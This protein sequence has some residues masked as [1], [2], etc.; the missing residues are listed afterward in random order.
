VLDLGVA[1]P[2]TRPTGPTGSASPRSAAPTPSSIVSRP[3]RVSPSAAVSATSP[4]RRRSRERRDHLVVEGGRRERPDVGEFG[5]F[6]QRP[7]PLRRTSVSRASCSSAPFCPTVSASATVSSVA[8]P[9]ADSASVAVVSASSTTISSVRAS[10]PSA[11]DVEQFVDGVEP[12]DE[13]RDRLRVLGD[14]R[15]ERIGVGVAVE[16]AGHR[17]SSP[18]AVSQ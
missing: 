18:R 11:R 4:G 6:V 2:R 9:S 15:F 8:M 1:D 17:Q 13:R 16:F 10:L 12:P 5:E 7:G 3:S 14:D